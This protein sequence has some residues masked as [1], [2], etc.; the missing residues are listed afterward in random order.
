MIK[1]NVNFKI[2]DSTIQ[3]AIAYIEIIDFKNN[4]NKCVVSLVM[5]DYTRINVIKEYTLEIDGNY[6]TIDDI[7]PVLLTYYDNSELE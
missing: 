6:T 1:W 3:T 2:P 7:Y 4:G 5:Y